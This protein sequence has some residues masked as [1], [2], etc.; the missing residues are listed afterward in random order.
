MSTGNGNHSSNGAGSHD[1]SNVVSLEARP[2]RRLVRPGGSLRHID[3]VIRVGDPPRRPAETRPPLA[4][5]LVLDRSGS[6]Q[7]DKLATAKRA[8]LSVLDGLEERDQVAVSVFDDRIETV[9]PVSFATA[10]TKERVRSQLARIQARANTALHEGWLLGCKAI[11]SDTPDTNRIARCFLLTDGLANVGVTDPEQIA[12]E[13]AGVLEHAGVGTS[14]FGVGL[15][16]NEALLAPMAVAGG[17]QFHNLR[18]AED[19]AHTFVGELGE[20]LSVAAAKVRLELDGGGDITAEVITQYWASQPRP[21]LSTVSVTVGDLPAREER[22]VVVRF[23]FPPRADLA[24]RTVRARVVWVFDGR[25]FAT[26]WQE[27][28]FSYAD[29]ADCD[30]ELRE[31]LDLTAMHWVGLH[32]AERA[33]KQ[34]TELSRRGD[35][36]GAKVLLDKVANRIAGYARSDHDL[37]AAVKDLRALAKELSERPVDSA[38]SKE[39]Y[40]QSLRRSR[41]QKDFR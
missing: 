6:M 31:R 15:D 28:R 37:Q 4:L 29:H 39:L 17:G 9:L 32:H 22:H 14:T 2:E 3:F 1:Y 27:S 25:E 24:E 13:A 20:L 35:L 19:I 5:S 23:G 34:A 38:T 40:F 10:D 21:G 8:A 16:Y 36:K 18:T 12:S 33:R 30:V 11:A 41:G 26:E 7:G